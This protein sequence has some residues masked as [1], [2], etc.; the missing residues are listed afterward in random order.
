MHISSLPSPYGI[1]TMGAEA[2]AFA[3]FLRDAGQSVWQLLPICPTSFGDSPYQSFS[4]F[5]GNPYFIDLDLLAEDGLLEP[6][7]YRSLCWGTNPAD[8]D[9]SLL[10]RTRYP[11]LRR[12]ARRLLSAKPADYDDF[13][14]SN[15]GWLEDYAVFMALKDAN[16]GRSWQE[17][18]APLRRRDPD[19][20]D[21]F[22]REHQAELDFWQAVQYLFF[23]QWRRLK[24]HVNGLGIS[25]IGDLPI[26]VAEDSAEVWAHPAEFQLDEDLRPI[27][28]AGCPPDGFSADGQLWGNP[29]FDWDRMEQD[30]FAWWR[31]RVAYQKSIF[32]ILR[33][34]HFR[35]LAAYYAIPSGDSTARNGRWRKGPGMKLLQALRDG[36][37]LDHVIAEDLGFLDA[38][39]RALL[40]DSGLPGMKVLQF[41]FDSRESGDYLP[42]NYDRHCVVYTG[43]HDN[44]TA[45]GWM[46]HAP[47]ADVAKAV[48]YLRLSQEEGMN[49]GL[50]RGAWSSVG[51]LAVVQMQDLLG[52]DGTARMNTPSTVGTNWRWRM[53]P[54][55]TTPA[56]A[57]RL[58][59]QMELYQRLPRS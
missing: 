48:E 45:Q 32:D 9:Y 13:C 11:V 47:R 55:G 30:G 15:R 1:G 25:L 49:W 10:Y 6:E 28:V 5:A 17:W 37:G 52:L 41:A 18:P 40:R 20:L 51:D 27:E 24:A 8:I 16:G 7:E 56:L 50:M 57:A 58:R 26:Y 12:A 22:R 14:A 43:T 3:E 38:D 35:G 34:D 36:T 33:I 2:F 53:L 44:D 42:H 23:R 46:E 29:L 19:A 39:V 21:R 54:G 4:S 59:H 31:S